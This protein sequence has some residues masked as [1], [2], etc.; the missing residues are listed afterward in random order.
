[1]THG[2][3][4]RSFVSTAAAVAGTAAPTPLLSACGG[5]GQQKTGTHTKAG[6]N[7]ALCG[8]SRRAGRPTA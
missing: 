3:N 8:A 6:L 7:A 2:V 1:M 5:G 4:R